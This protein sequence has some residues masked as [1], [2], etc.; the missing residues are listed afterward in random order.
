[1]RVPALIGADLSTKLKLLGCDVASFGVNH[2]VPDD[3][4][5]MV[6]NGPLSGVVYRKL[7]FNKAR[8]KLCGGILVGDAADYTKIHKIAMSGGELQEKNPAT[9]LAP[10]WARG[11]AVEDDS[12]ELSMDANAEICSCNGVT[13]GT[14]AAAV[15]KLGVDGATLPWSN[16]PVE[17]LSRRNW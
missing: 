16:S 1:M 3:V 14:I 4:T 8:T 2:P 10:L 13:R 12:E 6:W 9:L 17:Q 15:A 5:D 11:D 7:I